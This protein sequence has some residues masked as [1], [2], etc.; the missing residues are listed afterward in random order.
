MKEY[1]GDACLERRVRDLE[2]LARVIQT[3]QEERD[4]ARE[5]AMA[6]SVH[7]LEARLALLNELRGD[8]ITRGEAAK[9]HEVIGIR[10]DVIEKMQSRFVGVAIALVAMAGAAG[11]VLTHL[12]K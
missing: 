12:F 6:V 2:I 4:R 11:A 1:S 10:I 3:T 8:V 9:A 5:D 7:G